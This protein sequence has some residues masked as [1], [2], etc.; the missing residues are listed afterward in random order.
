MLSKELLARLS[1]VKRFLKVT[2][3]NSTAP[4]VNCTSCYYWSGKTGN[5]SS[6]LICAVAIPEPTEEELEKVRGEIAYVR[7]KCKDFR[8]KIKL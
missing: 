1:T 6:D 5:S 4:I 8:L 3:S 7:H 2:S